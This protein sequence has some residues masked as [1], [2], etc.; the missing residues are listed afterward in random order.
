MDDEILIEAGKLGRRYWVDLWRYR[1]LFAVMAWRDVSVRYKQ[2]AFGVAW[3]LLR[4]LLTMIVFV[5]VFGRV[6]HLP[7][8]G[9]PY[10]LLVLAAML[11]WQF[12][13]GSLTDG[14]A[15]LVNQ[16]NVI[17]KTYF[18][19]LVL[20]GSAVVVNL[21]D[22]AVSL[23]LLVGLMLWYGVPLGGGLLLFPLALVPLLVLG[24]GCALWLSALTVRYR[25][26]RFLTPF[27]VQF[28]LYV[29]PVGY[30]SNAVPLRYRALYD[31]NPLAPMLDACRF[32][33][34][35]QPLPGGC[36]PLA[37]ACATSLALLASGLW[38]FRGV[39][40]GFADVI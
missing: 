37:V 4:P 26:F 27:L 30:G 2:A 22:L 3:A 25:D 15:S 35:G 8:Q 9:A 13:S 28:G 24:L 34:L 32:C 33:V 17:S 19:R 23:P 16:A 5:F 10:P 14:S 36:L 7:A 12:F 18:P 39:E 31:L 21:F 29:S 11:P 1:E 40:R 6:A 38:Y 20:P